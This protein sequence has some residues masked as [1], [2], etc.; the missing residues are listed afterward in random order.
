M[1]DRV[2]SA[3]DD[4]IIRA[5]ACAGTAINAIVWVDFINRI[6]FAD[7]LNRAGI[8]AE[9]ARNTRICDLI[10]HDNLLGVGSGSSNT[11]RFRLSK[12][13]VNVRYVT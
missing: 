9:A 6:A 12:T 8:F 4:R 1:C 11:A 10:S 5:L 7:C 13:A 3:S 2:A